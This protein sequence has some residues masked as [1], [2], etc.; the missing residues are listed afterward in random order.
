MLLQGDT[1][2]LHCVLGPGRHT[3]FTVYDIGCSVNALLGYKWLAS[4][5]LQVLYEE[6]KVSMCE[7]AGCPYPT[8]RVCLDVASAVPKASMAA[9]M[10][11]RELG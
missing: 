7:K 11:P 6:G 3:L 4:H 8:R 5:N 10:S 1:L 2:L 9:L